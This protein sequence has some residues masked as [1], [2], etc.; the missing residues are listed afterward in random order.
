MRGRPVLRVVAGVGGS[1]GCRKPSYVPLVSCK[2]SSVLLQA[3]NAVEQT[4]NQ[5]QRTTATY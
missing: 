4:R 1:G 3:L 2:E 5:P